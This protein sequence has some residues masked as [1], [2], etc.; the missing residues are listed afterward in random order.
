M[1]LLLDTHALL[2]WLDDDPRLG[3]AARSLIGDP[4]NDVL[5][6]VVS[7]WEAQVKVRVGQ[8]EIDLRDILT[9]MRDQDFDLLA[10][11]PAHLLALGPL[12]LHHRDPW[13]HLLV[14]Q[15]N[16]EDAVFMSED[17]HTPDYPVTYVTCS[18]S[19]PPKLG[20]ASPGAGP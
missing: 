3:Q 12:P 15:A 2:W 11:A 20:G 7:L 4:T 5:V 13:D 18:G 6:S 14:A 17:R 10:I 8:L 1:R 19:A 9:E 16:A